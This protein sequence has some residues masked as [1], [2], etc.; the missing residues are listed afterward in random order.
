M[1]NS[2]NI[3]RGEPRKTASL[4]VFC[5][6]GCGTILDLTMIREIRQFR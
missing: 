6:H 5:R 2:S 3:R 1:S 4:S